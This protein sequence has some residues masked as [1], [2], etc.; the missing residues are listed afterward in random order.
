MTQPTASR[1]VAA[2][3]KQIGAALLIRSTRAVKL[4]EAGADY[5]SRC[6]D[7]LAAV[8]NMTFRPTDPQIGADGA[9]YFG[10]WSAALLGHM[11]Y[12]QRDPNRANS[13]LKLRPSTAHRNP[14]VG[15]IRRRRHESD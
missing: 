9:L 4:T 14:S 3:E 1:I 11:Q 13:T 2:L 12:S 8:D 5:L 6:E 7:I 15:P 10:D